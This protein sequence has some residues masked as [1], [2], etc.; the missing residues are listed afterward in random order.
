[1]DEVTTSGRFRPAARKRR[2]DIASLAARRPRRLHARRDDGPPLAVDGTSTLNASRI[3]W[4]SYLPCA[5]LALSLSLPLASSS[6]SLC[7]SSRCP[8]SRINKF[9]RAFRRVLLPRRRFSIASQRLASHE[10]CV[11]PPTP[12]LRQLLAY[13]SDVS[14]DSRFLPETSLGVRLFFFFFP[15]V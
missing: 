11:A 15:F 13:S 9:T 1:M 4:A 8:R 14:R 12:R 6:L 2:R 7:L 5:R 3:A 10:P